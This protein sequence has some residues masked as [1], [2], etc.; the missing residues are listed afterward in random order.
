MW[1]IFHDL[2]LPDAV[3]DILSDVRSQI[4]K[5]LMEKMKGRG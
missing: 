1:K 2:F 5:N 3:P 4:I